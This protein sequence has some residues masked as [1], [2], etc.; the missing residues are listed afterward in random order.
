MLCV[1]IRGVF[2]KRSSSSVKARWQTDRR[3]S[4]SRVVG[5]V[6]ER[7]V[8][9]GAFFYKRKRETCWCSCKERR[10]ASTDDARVD[11]SGHVVVRVVLNV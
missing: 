7:T 11:S 9:R 3:T 2:P 4:I 8:S 10:D 6:V 1:A 5:G